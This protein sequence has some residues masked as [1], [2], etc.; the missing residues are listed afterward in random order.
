M[1]GKRI[2][3]RIEGEEEDNGVDDNCEDGEEKDNC[4]DR[5]RGR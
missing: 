3:V 5:G 4:E 1:K 2:M